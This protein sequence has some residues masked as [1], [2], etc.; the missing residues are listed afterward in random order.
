MLGSALAC[1]LY[2]HNNC[3]RGVHIGIHM[4]ASNML[5]KQGNYTCQLIAEIIQRKLTIIRFEL[6]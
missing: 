1:I 6:L 5:Y 3:K 4:C 2:I